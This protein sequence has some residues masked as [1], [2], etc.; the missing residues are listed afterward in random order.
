MKVQILKTESS[1]LIHVPHESR[2]GFWRLKENASILIYLLIDGRSYL[3]TLT[4]GKGWVTDK[5][6]G[7]CVIDWYLPKDGNTLY[8]WFIAFHDASYSGYIPRLLADTILREGWKVSGIDSSRASVGYRAVR[9]FGWMG[10]Y[11][12]TDKLKPPYQ[13][14]RALEHL[15]MVEL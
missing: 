8:D 5:R 13:D 14:N 4:L 1:E 10:Y 12:V 15:Q 6:S 3:I 11:K 7:S 2:K 9:M